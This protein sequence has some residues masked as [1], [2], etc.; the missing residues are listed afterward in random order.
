ME[1]VPGRSLSEIIKQDGPLEPGGGRRHR[2]PG[3]RRPRRRARGRHHA[4]RREARQRAGPRGRRGQDQRLRHRPLG[5]RPGAD[6]VRLPHRHPAATS[7]P[8]SPAAP[9]P[10]PAPTCGRSARR[11]TPPSRAGRPTSRGPTRSRCCTTSPPASRR[12]PRARGLPGAGPAADD[13]PQP[14][15]PLVDGRR[16]PRPA[17]AGRHARRGRHPGETRSASGP[18]PPS[19]RPPTRSR[20]ARAGPGVGTPHAVRTY[21]R[22][23]T[24]RVRRGPR[25][26]AG[27]PVYAVLAARRR[28]SW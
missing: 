1:H 28:C 22:D 6:P 8:S 27:G 5:R 7:P 9:S 2:R 16:R 21:D 4:P 23:T 10:A 18:R 13:G 19:W 14:G 11:C 15:L 26:D 17:P 25:R 20:R 24:P 3:G 12:R